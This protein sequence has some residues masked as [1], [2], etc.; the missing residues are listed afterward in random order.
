MEN[1]E[2]YMLQLKLVS[3]SMSINLEQEGLKNVQD[4]I[5]YCIDSCI[6]SGKPI[7]NK[8]STKLIEYLIKHK[9]WSQLEMASVV[10][11]LKQLVILHI[12]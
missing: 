12:K 4:L 10:W 11:R 1:K 7:N 2:N 6:K 9:H 3:Y 5:S 8:T